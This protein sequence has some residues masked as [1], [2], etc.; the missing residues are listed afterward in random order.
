MGTTAATPT[1]DQFDIL[2]LD[3]GDRFQHNGIEVQVA[4]RSFGRVE[5][6]ENATP[7]EVVATSDGRPADRRWHEGIR[8][9]E[10]VY[11]ALVTPTRVYHGWLDGKTRRVVQTG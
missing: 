4:T 2:K 9:G 3:C 5:S 8:K 6:V 1:V 11:Y 10:D 7:V